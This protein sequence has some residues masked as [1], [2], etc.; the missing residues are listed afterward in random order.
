MKTSHKNELDLLTENTLEEICTK[1]IKKYP[2]KK[3]VKSIL[4]Y[5]F[6]EVRGEDEPEYKTL[7]PI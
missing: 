3:W 1:L 6:E 7:L 2:G 5:S 4:K